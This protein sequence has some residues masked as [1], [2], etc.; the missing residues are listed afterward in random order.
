MSIEQIQ[1]SLEEA[2]DNL[3]KQNQELRDDIKKHGDL[4]AEMQKSNTELTARVF[5]LEKAL[6]NNAPGQTE[7]A[8]LTFA[9]K[10][11]K[12]LLENVD[13]SG[14]STTSVDFSKAVTS[15]SAS[16]GS[17]I[18]PQYLPGIL[19][20]GL[21]RLTVRDLLAQGRTTSNSI[22]YMRELLFTNNAAGVAENTLKPESDIT[23]QAETA[24]VRTVAHWMTASKQVLAD[25][26]M[27]ES[28]IGN[29]LMYGLKLEEEAQLLNGD[30]SG[31]NLEGVNTVATAFDTS[32]PASTASLADQ[33]AMAIYQVSL[34]EFDASGIV[35]NT[36]D[37]FDL[38]LLKDANGNYILGGPQAFASKVLWGLPVV[39]TTA[40][41][42]GTFTVGAF[43]L[44]SQVWD[45]EEAN[46]AITPY[47][48]DNFVKNMVTILVE[49]RLAVT[50]YR[51][52][53]IVTGSLTSGS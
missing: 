20:P 51:P 30:G 10:A 25:A 23:F 34:S 2:R 46:I 31:Q 15:D 21:R 49:E 45:R 36:K 14:R 38:C 48:V 3:T 32:L 6:A 28:Y 8:Q 47:N 12:E 29:R 22:E 40:Q 50:H 18:T 26:P 33:L 5:D 35:L 44:A 43:D 17:L 27:L 24:N 16:A 37:W 19:T 4:N 39:A 52:A 13:K 42:Q 53:A 9:A 7:E 11:A 1:K 41:A